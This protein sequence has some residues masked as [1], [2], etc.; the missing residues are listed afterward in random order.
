VR[1]LCV[2]EAFTVPNSLAGVNRPVNLVKGII[3][4]LDIEWSGVISRD[5]ANQPVNRMRGTF[6]ENTATISVTASTPRTEVTPLSNGH[7]FRFVSHP[8]A[9]DLSNFAQ[10]GFEQ[11]GIFY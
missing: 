7:G 8:A 6:V 10:I 4:S 1:N 5:T 2:Y 3:E 11:N 9:T